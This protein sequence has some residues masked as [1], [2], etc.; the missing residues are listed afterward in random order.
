MNEIR[1]TLPSPTSVNEAYGT[2]F[3]TKRRFK[4][5]K[6]EEWIDSAILSLN[7]QKRKKITGDEWLHVEYTFYFPI[8]NKNGS[9]KIKDTFNYEKCLSDFLAENITGF[10]D[11]KIL[12]G[13]V[14]K[15]HS[16]RNEVEIVIVET[17]E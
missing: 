5:E 1:L 12:S 2:N 10:A 17:R 8:Y 13:S 3:T 6:Y 7:A 14:K 9:K 15:A 4:T 11:H 16:M